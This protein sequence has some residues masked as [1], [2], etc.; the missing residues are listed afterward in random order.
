MPFMI[1]FLCL[2]FF[3]ICAIAIKEIIK[4]RWLF[5][6]LIMIFSALAYARIDLVY[7]NFYLELVNFLC[8]R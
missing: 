1:G 8:K 2:G 3:I 6:I 7:Q 4:D 5:A